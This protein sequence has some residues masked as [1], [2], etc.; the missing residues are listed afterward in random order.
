M[1]VRVRFAPSPTG[2]LHV[3][4]AR[5]ALF[6]WL[7][8]RKEKGTF[9][10]RIE[11]TDV[12]RSSEDMVLG[13]LEGM[14]WLGLNWD[15]GPIFQSSRL[16]IYREKAEELVK[17]GKAYYCY[18]LPEEIEERRKKTESEGKVWMYDRRCFHLSE[19]EK[20]ELSRR[21]RKAIR[22]IVPPGKTIFKD[23]VHGELEFENKN[24]ED[25]VLLKSDGYPTY[26]LSVVVD[27]IEMGITHV[28]RGDDHLSNTPK[29]IM[30]YNAFNHS[31]PIFAHLP[32]ILGPDKKKLSKRHGHTSVTYF[33]DMGYHPLAMFNFLARLSW[34]PGEEKDIYTVEEM[35]ER[36]S[37]DSI[38]HNNPIFDLNKLD[39][40]NSRILSTFPPSFF[41]ND[42]KENLKKRKIWDESFSKDWIEKVISL[43]KERAKTIHQ[44]VEDSLPFFSDN[45]E[46]EKEAVEKYL[47]EPELSKY[48]KKLLSRLS[49][50][51]KF[52]KEDVERVCRELADEEG[53]KASILIHAIRVAL[54][55]K[56]VTPGVFEMM[57]VIGKEKC[58][59]RIERLISFLEERRDGDRN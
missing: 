21:G 32:L 28:I 41:F 3:G 26:H 14:Q 24:I 19:K 52:G 25:F 57:E 54:T 45:F 7:F 50:I 33:R 55:G 27:D 31:T 1:K 46:Y 16:E 30:L 2:Y 15:E 29:Q 23:V 44:L 51:K 35:I 48:L 53:I 8:A 6:N 34:S 39:W 12:Q 22:F 47:S 4:G 18:C 58:L 9:I 42:F 10:L 11:D 13:I 37:L 5:T 40:L 17:Q 20:E 43:F 49:L 56:R 36:F 59:Q 38:S